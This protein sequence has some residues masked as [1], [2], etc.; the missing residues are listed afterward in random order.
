VYYLF[1]YLGAVKDD[2]LHCNYVHHMVL[3]CQKCIYFN[4]RV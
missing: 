1:S 3:T 4:F 2:I